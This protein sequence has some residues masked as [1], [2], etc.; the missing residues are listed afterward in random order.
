MTYIYF[1]LSFTYLNITI[2]INSTLL[3]TFVTSVFEMFNGNNIVQFSWESVGA[4][5]IC[6]YFFLLYTTLYFS[7]PHYKEEEKL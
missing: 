4:E 3:K 7:C 6:N 1:P 5:V 2:L